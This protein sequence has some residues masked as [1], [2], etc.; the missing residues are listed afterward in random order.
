[1]LKYI[2]ILLLLSS[3]SLNISA[4]DSCISKYLEKDLISENNLLEL[5]AGL[6]VLLDQTTPMDENLKSKLKASL[7]EFFRNN[8]ESS[9]RIDGY[10][11]SSFLAGQYMQHDLKGVSHEKMLSEKLRNKVVK[12]DLKAFDSC[13]KTKSTQV[14]IKKVDAFIDSVVL[15]DEKLVKSDIME[16]EF[17]Q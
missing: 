11:Y 6:F 9:Y 13:Q 4:A 7:S 10:S 14:A 17:I 15:G 2:P 5:D 3:F 1:M 16:P 8:E 12:K